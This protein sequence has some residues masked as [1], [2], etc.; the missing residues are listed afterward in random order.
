MPF[1]ISPFILVVDPF[2][3]SSILK[4]AAPEVEKKT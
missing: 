4:I 2:A 3:F 1:F